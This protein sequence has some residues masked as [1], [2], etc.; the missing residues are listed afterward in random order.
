MEIKDKQLIVQLS[1]YLRGFVT[2]ERDNR[3]R[4]VLEKRTRHV[5]VAVED[6][7]QTQNISAVLRTCECYGVQDVHVIEN[8]N[9]FQIHSAISMGSNKWLTL[10]RY[11]NE[12]HN[13]ARCIEA[14]KAK[15]YTVVATLPNDDSLYLDELPVEEPTAFLFGTELTGL[16]E[17]AVALCDK[18]MKIPMYGFTESFNISNSAAITLSSFVERVRKSQVKWQLTDYEYNE[19]YFDWLQKSIRNSDFIINKYLNDNKIKI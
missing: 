4:E 12:A 15:G 10:H 19:L 11:K 14:L 18:S 16:S 17:E 6:L 13:T 3:I 2:E 9:E 1:E 5:T 8:E 7:Y